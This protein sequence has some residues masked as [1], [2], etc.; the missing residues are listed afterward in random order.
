MEAT[1]GQDEM[2]LTSMM[3][4]YTSSATRGAS[5]SFLG[6]RWVYMT[7]TLRA[8][9]HACRVSAGFDNVPGDMQAA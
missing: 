4:L 5:S 8:G 9:Q 7:L 3:I 2:R 6:L 1:L